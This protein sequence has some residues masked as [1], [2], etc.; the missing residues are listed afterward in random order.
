MDISSAI[1]LNSAIANEG[2][3]SMYAIKCIQMARQSEAI[4][5]D[6]LQDTVEI[7]KEAMDKYLSEV[8]NK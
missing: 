8:E 2:V 5:G 7:S 1:A 3:Q 4:V 6:L